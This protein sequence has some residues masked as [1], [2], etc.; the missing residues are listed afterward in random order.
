[1]VNKAS[2]RAIKHVIRLKIWDVK[3]IGKGDSTSAQRDEY[4]FTRLLISATIGSSIP[5]LL[6]NPNN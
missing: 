5:N 4:V 6:S 1:M 2:Q 3:L